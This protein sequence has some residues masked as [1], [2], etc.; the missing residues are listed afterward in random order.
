MARNNEMSN[1]AEVVA[2]MEVTD[3]LKGKS[4]CMTG[5]LGKPREEIA[6]LIVQAGGTVDKTVVYST[7]YLIT[8]KDWTAS[9][10]KGKSAKF[11]KAE[12]NGTKII[13]EEKFFEMLT[14][15]SNQ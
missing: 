5:H 4:F 6:R 15:D 13:S 14:K 7:N 3:T 1:V 2:V 12:R 11:A 8:N 9:T 10:V